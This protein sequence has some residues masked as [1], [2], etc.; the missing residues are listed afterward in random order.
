MTIVDISKLRC[1]RCSSRNMSIYITDGEVI[2]VWC[3]DEDCY[4]APGEII[5]MGLL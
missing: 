1:P 5:H 2:K 4:L 3:V